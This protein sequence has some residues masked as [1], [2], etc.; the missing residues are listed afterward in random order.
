MKNFSFI[1]DN[2]AFQNLSFSANLAYIKSVVQV[3]DTAY[4]GIS[5]R[6]LQ[7]QSPYVVN[8]GLTY[9]NPEN[10]FSITALYN[11]IGRR[12]SELGYK[13]YIDI[14]EAPRPQLDAQVSIPLLK[15]KGIVRLTYADIL[16]HDAIFYQDIDG[17]GKYEEEN[18][19][20]ITQ[21]NTGNKISFSF[22]YKF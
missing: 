11:I 5:E 15:D 13:D 16:N 3:E 20:R 12:I 9:F 1:S 4:Y 19:N 6:P 7:G 14:Y 18:D 2:P 8:A 21:I 22:T 10:G 17:S